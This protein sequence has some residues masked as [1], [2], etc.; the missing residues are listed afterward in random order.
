[1]TIAIVVLAANQEPALNGLDPVALTLGQETAGKPEF[2][3]TYLRYTY[4]FSSQENLDKFQND[5]VKY[6]IQLGG[7]C[8]N[9]GP[10]SGRG[11]ITLYAIADQKIYVFASEDC[12]KTFL[13]NPSTFTSKPIKFITPKTG[14]KA[15]GLQV[16][17]LA[18]KAHNI[19][20]NPNRTLRWTHDLKYQ[21]KGEEKI[22]RELHALSGIDSFL[23]HQF[24]VGTEGF[25]SGVNGSQS[26]ETDGKSTFPLHPDERRALR[27]QFMRHPFALLTAPSSAVLWGESDKKTFAVSIKGVLTHVTLDPKTN[28]ISETKFHDYVGGRIQSASQQFSGYQKEQTV[29]LP[30]EWF[31]GIENKQGVFEYQSDSY[32]VTN[33]FSEQP[34]APAAWIPDGFDPAILDTAP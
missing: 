14:S 29:N 12:R 22:W 20:E 32:K 23:Q 2:T 10:L 19:P 9:M 4:T 30:T 28:L 31:I 5:K 21:S 18:R 15:S 34:F 11:H 24:T 25:I 1:M 7:A 8:G 33:S 26:W 17:N 13:K 16:W 27:A 3:A 6:S